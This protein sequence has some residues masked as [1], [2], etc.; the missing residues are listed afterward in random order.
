MM[1]QVNPSALSNE[2]KFLDT[3]RAHFTPFYKPLIPLMN[4]IRKKIFP[5]D[6]WWMTANRELYSLIKEI[7]VNGQKDPEILGVSIS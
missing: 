1:V 4:K 2:S 6:S 7:L 5:N 3:T